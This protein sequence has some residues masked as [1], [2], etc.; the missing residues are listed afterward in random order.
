M[1][2]HESQPSNEAPGFFD[3]PRNVSIILWVFYIICIFLVLMDFIVHRHIYVEFEKLPTFYALYGFVACVVL[4]FAAKVL[5]VLLM[6][7]ENY[8]EDQQ[9]K[10][11]EKE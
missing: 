6:R 5:R 7:D 11:S 2:S 1:S 9:V 10:P 3:K 4:V 8:Y